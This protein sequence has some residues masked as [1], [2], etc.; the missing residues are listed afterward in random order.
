MASKDKKQ[1]LMKEQKRRKKLR[2]LLKRL[3]NNDTCSM[4]GLTCFTHD[5]QHWQTAPFWT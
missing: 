2:K 1:W 3:R 5:N 4:P